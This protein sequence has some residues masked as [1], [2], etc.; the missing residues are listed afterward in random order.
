MLSDFQ[1]VSDCSLW[2][3]PEALGLV[4]RHFNDVTHYTYN[5]F[6]HNSI[7]NFVRSDNRSL[8]RRILQ[9]SR[10]QRPDSSH[11]SVVQG[12]GGNLQAEQ[13]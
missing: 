12:Q 11:I 4:W 5:N 3:F 6:Q 10:D 1:A 9:V 13:D 7:R 8:Q 2:N